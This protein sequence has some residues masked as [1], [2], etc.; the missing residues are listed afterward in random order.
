[1]RDK[2][3]VVSSMT[4]NGA[5]RWTRY[6]L[7]ELP[8]SIDA[9]GNSVA[10]A[11]MS[12]VEPVKTWFQLFDS[13]GVLTKSDGYA[14]AGEGRA[15]PVCLRNG[16]SGFFLGGNVLSED[17]AG[18]PFVL[19]YSHSGLRQ[20]VVLP[21]VSSGRH[22]LVDL[23]AFPEG[24]VVMT[25][26]EQTLMND[27]DIYLARID[28]DGKSVWAQSFDRP[29]S[30]GKTQPPLFAGISGGWLE[31]N[32][33]ALAWPPA[34]DDV[35]TRDEICYNIYASDTQGGQDFSSPTL[36]IKGGN[37]AVLEGL[38]AGMN[39]FFVVRAVD[40][41]G[42]EDMNRREIMIPTASLGSSQ[43]NQSRR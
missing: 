22:R 24:G 30:A 6:I 25:A 5:E 11:T 29:G 18:I 32:K 17:G 10:L 27:A 35:S 23:R 1:M 39:H 36:R 9:Y 14:G 33:I 28:G 42:N 15:I 16:I 34:R 41:F 38:N 20:W 31:D 4:V 26:R 3:C 13:D 43:S 40:A 12:T 19:H 21:I 37:S 2:R 8:V 7:D